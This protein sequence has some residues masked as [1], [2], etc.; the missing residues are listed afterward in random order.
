MST[1]SAVIATLIE[2]SSQAS[3]QGSIRCTRQA[4]GSYRKE[5]NLP[6]NVP[7]ARIFSI[8]EDFQTNRLAVCPGLRLRPKEEAISLVE[9]KI[10]DGS[11]N[12]WRYEIRPE[13]SG[14]QTSSPPTVVA[15]LSPAEVHKCKNKRCNKGPNA[16]PA[17]VKSRRARY[18]SPACRVA[19]SRREG[20][21]TPKCIRERKR[22]RRADAKYP[23]NAQRQ[24]AYRGGL[25]ERRRSGMRVH[26]SSSVTDNHL[27]QPA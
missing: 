6:A 15:P 19:V 26:L 3:E 5:G 2:F 27:L 4:D 16:T 9:R 13:L 24:R 17:L 14:T 7:S 25:E 1:C 20:T 18:C 12:A 23:S 8:D 11:Y 22:K 10:E 21:P